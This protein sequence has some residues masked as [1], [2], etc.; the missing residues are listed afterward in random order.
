M[1]LSLAKKQE[2]SDHYNNTFTEISLHHNILDQDT[3]LNS[4]QSAGVWQ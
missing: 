1:R 2:I 4:H 3:T